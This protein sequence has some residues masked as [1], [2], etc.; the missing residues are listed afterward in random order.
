V[1]PFQHGLVLVNQNPHVESAVLPR[2]YWHLKGDQDPGVNNGRPVR[3][4][5]LMPYTGLILLDAPPARH[6]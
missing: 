2:V 3:A 4:V 5:R 6:S 1:R